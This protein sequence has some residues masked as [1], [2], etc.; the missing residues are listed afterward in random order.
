MNIDV[1]NVCC[2]Y[3]KVFLRPM[4]A[5]EF[6]PHFWWLF[7]PTFHLLESALGLL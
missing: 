6:D 3:N 4:L 5:H 1:L 2:A 7:S